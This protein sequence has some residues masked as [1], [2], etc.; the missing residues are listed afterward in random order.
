MRIII[1]CIALNLFGYSFSHSQGWQEKDLTRNT[2]K[3]I[4]ISSKNKADAEYIDYV[5]KE[6]TPCF[7]GAIYEFKEGGSLLIKFPG[8]SFGDVKG[9]WKLSADLSKLFLTADD[10]NPANYEIV[11]LG[12][13]ILEMQQELK[14]GSGSWEKIKFEPLNAQKNE[15]QKPVV[16]PVEKKQGPVIINATD[17]CEDLM[18]IL[19]AFEDRELQRLV[20]YNK[21][22]GITRSW[23]EAKVPLNRFE[24][25]EG[26]NMWGYLTFN[27]TLSGSRTDDNRSLYDVLVKQIGTCVGSAY[28]KK[29]ENN[30][31][32]FINKKIEGLKMD[33]Y[34]SGPG[35][36]ITLSVTRTSGD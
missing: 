8:C 30:R 23:Y 31:T 4:M 7:R 2:W 11:R 10:N 27:A 16:S 26:Q 3:L 22:L 21:P 24:V 34:Y 12:P 6:I 28:S 33:I 1:L 15:T 36:S 32:W 25:G 18:Y 19:S 29:V 13:D 17:F 9:T 35:K 20:D 14:N 5:D